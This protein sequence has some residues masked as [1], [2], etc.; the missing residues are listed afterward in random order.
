MAPRFGFRM[1]SCFGV[2]LFITSL[3]SF[4]RPTIAKNTSYIV[5][6]GPG[7]EVIYLDE[8]RRPALYTQNFGDCLG[9]SLLNVTRFDA[10]YYQDNMTVTF[11]L[12]GST[13]LNNESLLSAYHFVSSCTASG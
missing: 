1:A 7:G 3:L 13:A 9:D 11:H 5:A 10:A 6:N 8:D 12:Q 2:L 4:I